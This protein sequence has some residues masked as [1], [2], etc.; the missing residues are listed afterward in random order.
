MSSMVTGWLARLGERVVFVGP[1]IPTRVDTSEWG[2]L[3]LNV[4]REAA[5]GAAWGLFSSWHS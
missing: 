3:V 5:I 4:E 1:V 2:Q